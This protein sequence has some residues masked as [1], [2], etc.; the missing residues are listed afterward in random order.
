MSEKTR[1]SGLGARIAFSDGGSQIR[2]VESE[3]DK[4]GFDGREKKVDI[5]FSIV[6][7]IVF[8]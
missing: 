1:K 2:F 8:T 4:Y 6:D 7:A 5:D 3:W